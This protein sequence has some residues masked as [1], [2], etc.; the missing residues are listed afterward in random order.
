MRPRA[1]LQ[2]SMNAESKT[3]T[4]ARRSGVFITID[5]AC[6]RN[7]RMAGLQFHDHASGADLDTVNES[8]PGENPRGTVV[9]TVGLQDARCGTFSL[10]M[11]V[12]RARHI[13]RNPPPRRLP[14]ASSGVG[15]RV[16][17]SRS[18]RALVVKTKFPMLGRETVRGHLTGRAGGSPERPQDR[19]SRISGVQRDGV[20]P[21]W[22]KLANAQR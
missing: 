11:R 8:L 17:C 15:T 12:T 14:F 3:T 16:V 4:I 13:E 7:R 18:T 6:L 2:Y 22:K 5:R 10:R 9:T 20:W 21:V 19:N 1:Q